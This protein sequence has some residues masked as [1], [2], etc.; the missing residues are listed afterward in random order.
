M[1]NQEGEPEREKSPDQIRV[2]EL[3]LKQPLTTIN[4]TAPQL[5]YHYFGATH[6]KHIQS[7][8]KGMGK[9][10]AYLSVAFIGQPE[11]VIIVCPSNAMGAQ[12][13]EI[14]RHFPFYADKFTFVRGQKAQRYKLWRKPGNR[15]WITTPA[16]LQT[17]LG[18]RE[19]RKGSGQYSGS[20]VP[21]WVTSSHLDHLQGDEFQKYCRRPKSGTFKLL[22]KL[23]PETLILDSGSPVSTGPHELWP[24]LHLVDRKFWSSY[25]GYIDRFCVTHDGIFGKEIIGPKNVDQWRMATSP[26]VFHRQKD[27]RDYPPKSRFIMDLELEPWQR[28]LHDQLRNELWATTDSGVILTA[29]NTLDALYRARL[30]LICPKALDSSFGI[31]AGIEAIADDAAELSHFVVSTPFRAPIPHLRAY[32][33][34]L[35]RQVWVLSGGLGIGPDEQDRIIAEFQSTGGCLIQTIKYATSYEFIH[36]PEHNYFLGYEYDPEDNKQAEDRF[37]RI[38]S[39]RPSFHWYVRFLG[40]YDEEL[41]ENLV[42]KGQNVTRLMNEGRAWKELLK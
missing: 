9:T 25:W 5:L 34:S 31:G 28:K 1:Q 22:K 35:G 6:R 38:S 12:R 2:E 20:N 14:L 3:G 40:T 8:D 15:V 21:A 4:F 24:A 13:R 37:Q 32:L 29:R 30:G 41:I 10:V 16:T 23:H 26:Y 42:I 33:E 19:L 11:Y 18:G 27:P 17:D 7:M 39:T 36:G